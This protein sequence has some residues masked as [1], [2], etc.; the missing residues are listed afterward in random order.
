MYNIPSIRISYIQCEFGSTLKPQNHK[1]IEIK[2][3]SGALFKGFYS[4]P[5]MVGTLIKKDGET[6][7]HGFFK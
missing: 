4:K 2:F 3:K 1:Q 5:E 6:K 7:I